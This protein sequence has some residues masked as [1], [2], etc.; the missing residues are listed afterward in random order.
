MKHPIFTVF[1]GFIS[2]QAFS[3]DAQQQCTLN[4][5]TPAETKQY[6][7]CLD[8]V[9]EDLEREQKM[10]VNKLTLDLE[11]IKEDTGNSQ[12]LPIFLRSVK[13]QASYQEDSCRWRYLQKMPNATKAAITYK[14]CEIA[15]LNQHLNV[16][17]QP[18]K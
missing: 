10:W 14:Q 4:G 18:L 17:K 16:L 9:I 5:N 6:I 2:F 15:I 8:K 3:I 1:L 11:K 7:R 12:L 13:N